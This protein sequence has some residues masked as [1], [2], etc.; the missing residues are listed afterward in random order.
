MAS[1]SPVRK[2]KGSAPISAH[3]AFPLVVALWF[4]AL[5]GLGSLILPAALIERLIT[6]TGLAEF[7]PAAAPPLGF[8]ARAAIAL[9]G[10][11]LGAVLGLSAARK[12]ARPAP[13]APRRRSIKAEDH[14]RRAPLSPREELGSDSFDSVAGFATARRRAL[15]GE[16]EARP[17]DFLVLAPLPGRRPEHGFA[18]A[19]KI[20]DHEPLD[21]EE[22]AE[23]TEDQEPGLHNTQP[24]EEI[25]MS[26]MQVFSPIPAAVKAAEPLNFSPPSMARFA[27]AGEP[28][29]EAPESAEDDCVTEEPEVQQLFAAPEQ[30]EAAEVAIERDAGE[31]PAADQPANE[32]GLVQLVQR[33]GATLERHREWSA[34]NADRQADKQPEAPRF[35][36]VVASTDFDVAAPDEAAL[37][38]AAF[39]SAADA[40]ADEELPAF[41]PAAAEASEHQEFVPVPAAAPA[42][43]RQLRPF[44]GL[45]Q[46]DEEDDEDEDLNQ[47]AASLSLP[48]GRA[49]SAA[50][51]V[52]E[53]INEAAPEVS[54]GDA[55]AGEAYS[56]LMVMKNPFRASRPE[57][58][59]VDEPETMTA[60]PA[61]VFPHELPTAT[62]MFDRP[63]PSPIATAP[64]MP[65]PA[66]TPISNEDNDRVLRE[67]L[68]NLQR[69][70][71]N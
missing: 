68:M 66:R 38:M 59:R 20:P 69:I 3:P 4:A 16:E 57:F 22:C 48:I 56:S 31:Q 2:T 5:L 25:A 50:G 21:L 41:D 10:T 19:E 36:H 44:A 53:R 58:V 67:A 40:N 35:P 52:T 1:I 34:Q 29:D 8:T 13:E 61:V 30:V 27:A 71:K 64:E 49:A 33:L 12:I 11:V 7:V 28:E 23:F 60:E 14:P 55:K 54:A 18:Y 43:I 6:A 24:E 42:S 62:R 17:S 46:I 39:F 70:A 65:A 45:S 37:A 51:P 63:S 47:L 15:A 9:G 32:P 26:Q